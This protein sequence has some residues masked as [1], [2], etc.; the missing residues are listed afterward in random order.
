L[1][2]ILKEEG[3]AFTEVIMGSTFCGVYRSVYAVAVF[4]DRFDLPV[5]PCYLFRFCGSFLLALL[6]SPSCLLDASLE[7]F[8]ILDQTLFHSCL[9]GLLSMNSSDVEGSICANQFTGIPSN[10]GLLFMLNIVLV[11]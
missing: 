10:A 8:P 4:E 3:Y 11:L 5:V 1:T 7:T 9:L 2:L 6:F